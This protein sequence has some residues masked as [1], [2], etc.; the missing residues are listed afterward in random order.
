MLEQQG[1]DPFYQTE[2]DGV[3]GSVLLDSCEYEEVSLDNLEDLKTIDVDSGNT[4]DAY[5]NQVE[6]YAWE[7]GVDLTQDPFDELL[8]P[9]QKAEIE[10]RI[11]EDYSMGNDVHCDKYDYLIAAF[12]GVASGLI[13]VFFVGSPLDSKLGNWT[14]KETDKIVEKFAKCVQATDK[15][16]GTSIGKNS[17]TPIDG[18]ASAI[19]YLEERFNVN[20]DAHYQR[21]FRYPREDGRE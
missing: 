16:K 6:S 11:K 12:S 15:K 3:M 13:D 4:W 8:S 19:G 10:Q 5:M 21:L 18:I 1:M 9:E 7:N 14:N 20:Y 2:Q 17:R